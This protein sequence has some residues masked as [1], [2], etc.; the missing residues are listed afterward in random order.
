MSDSTVYGALVYSYEF[1][2]YVQGVPRR[3]FVGGL[4]VIEQE[5]EGTWTIGGGAPCGLC[6]AGHVLF[7]RA[8]EGWRE[9]LHSVLLG[10]AAEAGSALE[11]DDQALEFM[12]EDPPGHLR[13]ELAGAVEKRAIVHR[14]GIVP[15]AFERLGSSW[16]FAYL[17][18]TDMG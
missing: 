8:T 6:S 10:M 15:G 1:L 18:D 4:A 12:T 9:N 13:Q 5:P 11:F 7:D 14:H 16:F 2:I 3:L 17:P